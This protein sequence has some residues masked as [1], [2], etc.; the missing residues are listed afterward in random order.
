MKM[1]TTHILMAAAVL[2]TACSKKLDYSYDNRVNQQP[3]TASTMRL[4]NLAGATEL[5]INGQKLTSFTAPDFEGGYGPD[6]TRGTRWFPENGRL[7]TTY[8]IPAALLKNGRADSIMFSSLSQ[9]VGAPPA[10][11]FSAVEDVNK[12]ADYYFVRFRPNQAG[13][14]DSLFRIPR[15]IS[16]AVDAGS[17][18]VRLLNLSS[19]P[20]GHSVPGLYRNG[21]M[22]V[23]LADGTAIPGLSNVAPG[24][25]SAYVEL[26]YGTYQFKVL[27]SEGKEVPASG[28]YNTTNPVTGTLMDL[29]GT[30]GI[31]GNKDTWLT[32]APIKTYQPGGIYTIVVAGSMETKIPTGN[33]NGETTNTESN[34]FRIIADVPEPVNISYARIQGV[35]AAAGKTISWQVD[36]QPMGAALPYTKQTTY[37]RYTTGTHIVKALGD[38]GQ[39]LA[40]SSLPLQPGD[41]LTLWYYHRKDGTP[42]ISVS[43]NN[44]SGKYFGGTATE[45]GSYGIFKDAWPF[46]IRFMNFCPDMEEV[47]F[48]ADNGL[49]FPG[50][51]TLPNTNS[52]A[53]HIALGAP[54]TD[55]PY[56]MMYVN[57]PSRIFSYASH[58]GVLPGDWIRS[59]TPLTSRNFIARPELYK[60]PELPQSEPGVYTVALVGS[61]AANATE[62]ARMI[63]VKHNN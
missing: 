38:G 49:P 60:T 36:G 54:M 51:N 16:P 29:Q 23:T 61:T 17:C 11:P 25:Y 30:P 6:Q 22:S 47:T 13:F 12:P 55:N 2:L 15:D 31:G 33:P 18:K 14:I 46:W 58:P 24:A 8:T 1:K 44:M 4:V 39:V 40:E 19:T 37:S 57:F 32:F 34:I 26:P 20:D 28:S 21:P 7:G 5:Q 50:L 10:R 41:N 48:T 63:I 59:I 42:A 9:K 62:K 52:A 45:D 53:Q 27:N 35:N 43:A 56:V 3:L